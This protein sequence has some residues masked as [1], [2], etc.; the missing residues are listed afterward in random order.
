MKKI[1]LFF[2]VFTFIFM[3]CKKDNQLLI[4]NN[5]PNYP[6]T[7]DKISPII[8]EQIRSN[9]YQ[10]NQYIKSSLNDFGFCR[11]I[12]EE[13]SVEHPPIQNPLTQSEAVEVVKNFVSKNSIYTGILNPDELNFSKL[14]FN[15]DNYDGSTSWTIK[16][17]AQRYDTLEVLNTTII[18]RIR[19]R[20]LYSCVGNWFPNI[21]IP[22]E[23]NVNPEKT[24]SILLFKTVTH[25]TFGGDTYEVIISSENISE[26][27]YKLEVI[28]IYLE[29][30]IELR[31]AWKIYLPAPVNYEIYIDVMTGEILREVPTI[32]S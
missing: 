5:D 27:I 19:N 26:S 3:A 6:T 20:E 25:Y 29:N 23:F 4:P 14:S 7:I 24:K 28:P 31:I 9:Y 13:R 16:S 21:Y 22:L 2:L 11:N 32:I 15:S 17:L 1:I 10:N 18:F 30:K 12:D 8:L